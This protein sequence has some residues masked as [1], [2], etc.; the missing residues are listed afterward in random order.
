MKAHWTVC[1]AAGLVLGLAGC[2][3]PPP[4]PVVR[5]TGDP[6]VDGEAM[7]A[8]TPEKDRVLL[9]YKTALLAMRTGRFDVAKRLLDSAIARIGGIYGRDKSAE[10]ARGFFHSES[11]KTF[12][13]EPYERVMA[14]HYRGILYWMDGEPDNARACFRSAEIMDSQAEDQQYASD[15]MLL[16]Y[17]DALA[18]VKLGGDGSDAF[19]LAKEL[20]KGRSLPPLDPKANVLIFFDFGAGPV[21][22]SGGR[23]REQLRFAP[24]S[25]P[26]QSA[27]IRVEAFTEDIFPY[28]DLY[29]QATTRGGRAMDYILEGKAHWKEGTEIGGAV[30]IGAGAALAM[31]RHT[32]TAGLA[33]MGAGILTELVSGAIKTAADIR[34][35]DNLPQ[36]ISFAPLRMQP[37]PH[38]L[39]VDFKDRSGAV[40]PGMTKTI[41]FTVPANG[42]DK[43]IFVSDQSSAMLNL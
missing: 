34:S 4:G 39:F 2:Q 14:Y 43:V 40:I 32:E 8:I 33:L 11:K 22:Y 18:T 35:W 23:Y 36:Y 37:G 16:D 24:G 38:V 25:S 12:I 13:G 26:V 42:A 30:A 17:L 9:E 20:A 19:K 1:L 15:Y 28:D 41:N 10:Q 3:S 27:D 29:F 6:V 21:K 31:D 7:L 5:M